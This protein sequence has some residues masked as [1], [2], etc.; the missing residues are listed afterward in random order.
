MKKECGENKRKTASKEEQGWVW[1]QKGFDHLPGSGAE[2]KVRAIHC[3]EQCCHTVTEK[4]LSGNSK[5]WQ[6]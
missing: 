3:M 5:K 4:A 1:G 6:Q 2:G